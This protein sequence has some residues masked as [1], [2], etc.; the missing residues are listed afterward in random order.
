MHLSAE[1]LACKPM[2]RFVDKAKAKKQQP[3]LCDVIEGLV[4]EVEV[5]RNIGSKDF[6]IVEEHDGFKYEERH[7]CKHAPA[8]V[9]E[10]ADVP[11][12]PGEVAIRI[13]SGKADVDEVQLGCALRTAAALGRQTLAQP[14]VFLLW[15]LE[16]EVALFHAFGEGPDVFGRHGHAI[17]FFI[18]RGNF[19][20][21]T[22]AVEE[23]REIPLRRREAIESA[24]SALED[25]D[26][27]H[28]VEHVFANHKVRI[29]AGRP[30]ALNARLGNFRQGCIES[31]AQVH[32]ARRACMVIPGLSSGE[33][34]TTVPITCR[35]PLAGSTTGL[36]RRTL[37]CW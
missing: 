25:T 29:N 34:R 31:F 6:P 7:Y 20:I 26:D 22:S 10:A 24:F 3:E 8:V 2:R 13:P 9:D 36:T 30:A 17:L 1:V 14:E 21:G 33:G 5:E 19:I 28:T 37:A 15:G 35:L 27:W 32:G 18:E 11:V 16:P 23:Q 12:H 4:R